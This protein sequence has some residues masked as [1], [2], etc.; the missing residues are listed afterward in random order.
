MSR[1]A[2]CRI[3]DGVG[4]KQ[5]NSWVLAH[6]DEVISFKPFGAVVPMHRL[7]V[8]TRHVS[9]AD[10]NPALTGLV[11]AQAATWASGKGRPFNL[12]VNSGAVAGQ[13]VFHLH[14]HYVPRERGDGLGYRWDGHGSRFDADR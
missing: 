8:P 6:G 11:F 5:K 9:G 13:S 4:E 2:F 14:V 1:C 3:V 7:F 10:E 12:V